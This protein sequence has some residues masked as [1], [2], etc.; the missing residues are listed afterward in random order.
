[1]L[2]RR[3]AFFEFFLDLTR[4]CSARVVRLFCTCSR[5]TVWLRSSLPFILVRSPLS[6]SHGRSCDSCVFRTASEELAIGNI[7]FTTYDLGGHQQGM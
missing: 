2:E 6:L 7:K 1:M 4:A 3:W 5:T